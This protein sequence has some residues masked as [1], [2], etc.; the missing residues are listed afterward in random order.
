M[1]Q[2]EAI[3]SAGTMLAAH[4]SKSSGW[5]VGR[6]G[7][8]GTPEGVGMPARISGWGGV[9]DGRQMTLCKLLPACGRWQRCTAVDGWP[10]CN[11]LPRRQQAAARMY[12]S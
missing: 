12:G 9:Q 7:A 4:D 1:L 3:V 10:L 5:Y 6:G 8:A 11:Q 2:V